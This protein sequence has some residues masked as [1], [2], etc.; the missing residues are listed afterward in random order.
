MLAK[1]LLPVIFTGS[2]LLLSGC[3]PE[4]EKETSTL[5]MWVAPN[6][7][8]ETFWGGVIRDWNAIPGNPKIEFTAIPVAGSSEEA[9]MNALASGT[10]PDISTNIFIGFATQL[11]ELGQ[12]TNLSTLEGY[13]ALVDTRK[14]KPFTQAWEINGENYVIPIYVSPIVYWWRGDLL[15]K[16][17]IGR[18]PVTYEEVY[19][20]SEKNVAAGGRYSM[21]V[22]AGKN[23][24]DRWFDFV[25]L[26][27]AASGNKPYLNND[28]A[29]FN[30]PAGLEVLTFI[31]K[32]FLNKWSSY[33]FTSADDPLVTGDVIGAVRGPWDITRYREQ[34]PAILATI[35]IGPMLTAA[36]HAAPATM[37]DSK[38]LV[39]FNSSDKKEEAWKFIQWVYSNPKYDVKWL[40]AT[41]MPPAREDLLT[42]PL[43]SAYLENNPLA[44]EIISYVNRATPPAAT[45][46]TIDVQRSMT[47][48]IERTIFE[49]RSPAQA[50]QTSADEI[51]HALGK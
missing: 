30:N 19:A 13:D 41:N 50:L 38:G 31:Q 51:N 35:R 11:A 1:L 22:T 47:Q 28:R 46:R 6:I 16:L 5:K 20:L 17:G 37:A 12:L 9:I 49:N 23:W 42:N 14:M 25:P 26:Y 24:W 27:Y 48:M 33:D 32:M 3:G 15:E 2:T 10:E 7:T 36:G 45:T 43:F 40:E 21:Q 8:Q 18:V 34:Y 44:K 29:V 4:E 39:L